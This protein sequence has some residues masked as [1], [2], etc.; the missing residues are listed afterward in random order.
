MLKSLINWLYFDLI[1][2]LTISLVINKV[3]LI[4]KKGCYKSF[5]IVVIL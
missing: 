5:E 1:I 2:S 3:I 4:K